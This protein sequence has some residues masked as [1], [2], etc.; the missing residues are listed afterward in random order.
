[1]R[2]FFQVGHLAAARADWHEAR[3]CAARA[4]VGFFKFLGMTIDAGLHSARFALAKLFMA[5]PAP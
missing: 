5:S 4:G 2:K 3:L 1:L